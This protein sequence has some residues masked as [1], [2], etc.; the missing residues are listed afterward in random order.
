MQ[1]NVRNF[2]VMKHVKEAFNED[3]EKTITFIKEYVINPSKEIAKCQPYAIKR[4]GLMPS[5][6][7]ALPII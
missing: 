2:G 4:F 3:K 1:R 7:V 6:N 5:Q